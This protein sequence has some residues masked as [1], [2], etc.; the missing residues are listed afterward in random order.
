MRVWSL[1][2]VGRIRKFWPNEGVYFGTTLQQ[3]RV[4]S[5]LGT[6]EFIFLRQLLQ[7]WLWMELYYFSKPLPFPPN[8]RVIWGL[9]PKRVGETTGPGSSWPQRRLLYCIISLEF[10]HQMFQRKALMVQNEHPQPYVPINSLAKCFHTVRRLWLCAGRTPVLW[11]TLT[12]VSPGVNAKYATFQFPFCLPKPPNF[13]SPL[14]KYLVNNCD[15]RGFSGHHPCFSEQTQHD[16]E[17]IR[18]SNSCFSSWTS[19]PQ[20]L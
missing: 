1:R 16:W 15:C 13:P 11:G 3:T 19:G 8:W 17:L 7:I 12:L 4:I 18:K 10:L 6:R 9:L 14:H 20:F 2:S 5:K